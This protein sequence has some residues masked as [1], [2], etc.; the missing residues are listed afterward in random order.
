MEWNARVTGLDASRTLEP[1]VLTP[2]ERWSHS[3]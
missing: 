1:F 2:V 3:S